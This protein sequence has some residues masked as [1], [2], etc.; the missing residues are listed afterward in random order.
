[1][2]GECP[3]YRMASNDAQSG[4]NWSCLDKMER[5]LQKCSN[6]P[7]NSLGEWEEALLWGVAP[8]GPPGDLGFV[9]AMLMCRLR[10]VPPNADSVNSVLS[11]PVL[12]QQNDILYQQTDICQFVCILHQDYY[13]FLYKSLDYLW[14]WWLIW[15]CTILILHQYKYHI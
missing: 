12:C 3:S 7:N 5:R 14:K 1:M 13:C 9:H 4:T 2:S 8:T 11:S 6:T 10:L 15:K